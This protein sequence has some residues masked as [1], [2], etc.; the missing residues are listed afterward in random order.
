[1][2]VVTQGKD[3]IALSLNGT[4][5]KYSGTSYANARAAGIIV[6]LLSQVP[7]STPKN[8]RS[9]IAKSAEVRDTKENIGKKPRTEIIV[10]SFFISITNIKKYIYKNIK[11]RI[12]IKIINK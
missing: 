2:F 8:I 6:G 10:C 9:A 11:L 12:F 4:I 7:E 1:M 3:I 5:K